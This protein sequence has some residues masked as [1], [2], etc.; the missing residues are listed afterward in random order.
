MPAEKNARLP[1]VVRAATEQDAAP[2]GRICYEAFNRL[3]LQHCF[4]PDF[5]APEAAVEILTWMFSHP[6]FYCRVADHQ[7]RIVGSNCLDERGDQ[8]AG[9]GPITI[10][11]EFQNKGI[12]KRLI[13]DALARVCERSFAGVR[14]IQ[15][16]FH[17]RSMSLYTKLGFVVRETLAVIQGVARPQTFQGR[18]IR[19]AQI[20]DVPACNQLCRHVHGH[21]RGAELKDGISRGAARVVE[22]AG[23]ITAYSSGLGFFG[24][25]VAESNY[26]MKALLAT[27]EPFSGPGILVPTRNTDLFRWCLESG[28]RIV[29]PM[30]LMT[31]GMY[32]E[33]AGPYL[34]SVLF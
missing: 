21:D 34:A 12:G 16:T 1:V 28:M 32:N 29:E 7:G 15:S 30:T 8:I 14:L 5:P 26:D 2:C 13:E 17:N 18:T 20:A 24:Y 27:T 31:I 19:A 9:I 4:P 3:N 11:P 22:R 23:A 33:P 6:E 10:D 25:S